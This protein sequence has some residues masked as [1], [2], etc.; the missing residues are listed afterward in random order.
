MASFNLSDLSDDQIRALIVTLQKQ[1]ESKTVKFDEKV[2]QVQQQRM[3]DRMKEIERNVSAIETV[4]AAFEVCLNEILGDI[5][6]SRWIVTEL[7]KCRRVN[8]YRSINRVH[9]KYHNKN[10][11]IE[12]MLKVLTAIYRLKFK[13]YKDV[14]GKYQDRSKVRDEVRCPECGEYARKL[15][16]FLDIKGIKWADL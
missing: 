2:D 16:E 4:N 8:D 12:E 5:E 11:K 15:V 9:W 10:H 13:S 6:E 3:A 7:D 1:V 14:K